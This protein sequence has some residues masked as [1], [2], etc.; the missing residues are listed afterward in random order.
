MLI[1]L[2]CSWHRCAVLVIICYQI[3]D[4]R[5][6]DI[7]V[8]DKEAEIAAYEAAANKKSADIQSAIDT[9]VVD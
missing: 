9:T 3:Q 6:M 5:D 4:V 7:A 1:L 2:T 8:A